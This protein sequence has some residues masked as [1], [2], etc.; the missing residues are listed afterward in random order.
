MF[1]VCCVGSEFCCELVISSEES[2]REGVSDSVWSRNL[3][4]AVVWAPFGMF[5][6]RIINSNYY[7][8]YY[9][10]YYFISSTNIT[11]DCTSK[12]ESSFTHL[13]T[14]TYPLPRSGQPTPRITK[15]SSHAKPG[16]VIPLISSPELKVYSFRSTY[17]TDE[18]FALP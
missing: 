9:Y 17:V 14:W 7:Q 15:M 16:H 18:D 1:V 12:T 3:K 2:Y 10:Y 6:H 13:D 4:N 5:G 8:H 11:M